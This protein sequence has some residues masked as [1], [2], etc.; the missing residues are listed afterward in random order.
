[1]ARRT[2][3]MDVNRIATA[4]LEAA[5]HEDVEGRRPRRMS[6]AKAMVA[7]AALA[8]AA[9]MA[10]ARNKP[11]LLGPL[12]KLTPLRKLTDVPDAVRDRWEDLREQFSEEDEDEEQV[13]EYPDLPDD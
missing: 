6:G 5:F 9:R 8:T 11:P 13:V 4:A 1:M 2:K 7:G 12:L 3:R 10:A